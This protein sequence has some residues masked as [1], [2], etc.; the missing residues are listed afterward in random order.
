LTPGC[1]RDGLNSATSGSKLYLGMRQYVGEVDLMTN[2]L[3]MLVPSKE[4]LNKLPADDE[5]RL[6][7]QYING[8]SHGGLPSDFCEQMEKRTRAA[9]GKLH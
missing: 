9:A 8:M 1:R 5:K 7:A 6:R 3:R 4:F 2:K